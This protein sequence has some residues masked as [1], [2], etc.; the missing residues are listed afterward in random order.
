M[1]LIIVIRTREAGRSLQNQTLA[2]ELRH[3]LIEFSVDK[4]E[5]KLLKRLR[6]CPERLALEVGFSFIDLLRGDERAMIEASLRKTNLPNKIL[7]D[8]RRGNVAQKI[9]AAEASLAFDGGNIRKALWRALDD[10][11]PDVRL[12]AAISLARLRDIRALGLVFRLIGPQ[13]HISRRMLKFFEAAF[14]Q[15]DTEIT[16]YAIDPEQ[17]TNVRVCAVQALSQ[18]TDYRFLAL[19]SRLATN[20]SNEVAAAAIHAL[21]KLGHPAAAKSI[22]G[23]LSH[24]DW[25]V[26]ARAVMAV[27]KIGLEDAADHL[28]ALLQSDENWHV[29]FAA[30]RSLS[31]LGLVGN[32]T[33]QQ[34]GSRSGLEAGEGVD[35]LVWRELA[36]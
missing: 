31:K 18:R 36:G 3:A 13:G 15:H 26:R 23:A 19:F 2:K 29:R 21:G 28:V 34:L 5:K 11:S 1:T 32:S 33:L 16:H 7:T 27:G 17:S 4:D 35:L 9:F 12:A 20:P 30:G 14:D 10:R 25:E 22:I 8:L 6:A 24:P